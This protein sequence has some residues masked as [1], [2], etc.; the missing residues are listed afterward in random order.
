MMQ[1]SRR[2]VLA[3]LTA[4][5]TSGVAGASSEQADDTEDA[6]DSELGSGDP[7]EIEDTTRII[8][9]SSCPDT[10]PITAVARVTGTV[11]RLDES[12]SKDE[13]GEVWAVAAEIIEAPWSMPGSRVRLTTR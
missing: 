9:E 11:Q 6:S 2:G 8:V 1:Y 3:A 7:I 4:L 12:E 13:H 5:G 10:D